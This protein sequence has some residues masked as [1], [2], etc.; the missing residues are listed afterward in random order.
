M[1]QRGLANKSSKRKEQTPKKPLKNNGV[2]CFTLHSK[3][4]KK[5]KKKKSIAKTIIMQTPAVLLFILAVF[6]SYFGQS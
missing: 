4:K 6:S 3:I 5:K 2:F 1:L